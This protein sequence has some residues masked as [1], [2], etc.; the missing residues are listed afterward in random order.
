MIVIVTD[1]S[2]YFR[3][4]E[5]EK[6][7]IRVIPINYCVD[8]Q[9]FNE[10]YS[11]GNGDFEGLLANG[12]EHSTAHPNVSAYLSCFE[13][14]LRA[15][16]QVLCITISSRLSGAYG[17]ADMAAQQAASPDVAVLDSQLTAGGLY[18]LVKEAARLVAEGR[19]LE[20]ARQELIGIRE[21]I[22]IT[23]SVD[24]MEP[25]RKSG[26][27]GFVRMNVST[28]LNNRP[29]LLC[30]DGAVVSDGIARGSTELVKALTAKVDA[31]TKE[32]VLSYVGESRLTTTL[33]HVIQE[34]Y[35]AVTLTLQKIGPVLGIHL[36]IQVVAVSTLRA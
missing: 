13:E 4:S 2:S 21:R 22:T 16:N 17:T 20:E 6:L 18:L 7:G 11:D 29:I 8:G 35:P 34:T 30:Q 5:A 19:G 10:S 14:E 15:K 3:R 27:I 33:Y 32:V 26:R 1:S 31:G 36:G 12:R 28:F 25:L 24:D 9:V 23:F